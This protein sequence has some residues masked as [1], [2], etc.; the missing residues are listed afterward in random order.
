MCATNAG[1]TYRGSMAKAG[2]TIWARWPKL[3][4]LLGK[5]KTKADHT[6]LW[7]ATKAGETFRG[8]KGKAG[9]AIWAR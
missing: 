6:A 4:K 5:G 1:E 2:Q 8:S 3:M 7:W 9:Q